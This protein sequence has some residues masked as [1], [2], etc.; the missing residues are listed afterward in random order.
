MEAG[1]LA[2]L[3]A[4]TAAGF[5]APRLLLL[6]GALLITGEFGCHVPG[7]SIT[8]AAGSRRCCLSLCP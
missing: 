2:E 4:K 3:F 5:P 6:L 8:Q 7:S 1:G